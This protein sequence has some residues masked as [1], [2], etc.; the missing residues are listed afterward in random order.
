MSKTMLALLIGG[1]VFL[2]ILAA[3]CGLV[4]FLLFG[5]SSNLGF[6]GGSGASTKEILA[7]V[8]NPENFELKIPKN[9]D[10]AISYLEIDS[11]TN[12]FRDQRQKWLAAEWLIEQPVEP[13]L[14]TRASLAL[15]QSFHQAKIPNSGYSKALIRAFELWGTTEN[16][17]LFIATR[18]GNED[19]TPVLLKMFEKYPNVS[20]AGFVGDQ[21][22]TKHITQAE[23][24]LRL[25][26]P[27]AAQAIAQHYDSKSAVVAESVKKMYADWGTD[28]TEVRLKYYIAHTNET[29]HSDSAWAIIAG[30]PFVERHQP[31]VV[32]ALRSFDRSRKLGVE[33]WL[34]ACLV[35]GDRSMLEMVQQ[36]FISDWSYDRAKALQ[37]MLKFPDKSSVKIIVDM[38]VDG[39]SFTDRQMLANALQQIYEMQIEGVD[40]EE[41]VHKR[42]VV[43]YND[44][45]TS[46][47][48][49]LKELLQ[50]T[51]F[52]TN[53]LVDQSLKELQSRTSSH[54]AVETLS[55]MVVI[56]ARRDEV[57][58]AIAEIIKGDQFSDSSMKACFL[59][60]ATPKSQYLYSM[61]GDD[62]FGGDDWNNALRIALTGEG[63]EAKLIVPVAQAMTDFHKKEAVFNILTESGENS[64]SLML[65]LLTSDNAAEL[66][67]ACRVLS[68]VGTEKSMGPLKKAFDDAKKKQ[69][70]AVQSAA[71]LAGRAVMSRTGAEL[72]TDADE[73]K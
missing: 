64:E 4:G 71:A 26:G 9:V 11:N 18:F 70:N 27:E 21:L 49:G 59:K 57:A 16:V 52:D 47:R 10:E 28:V 3:S 48:S 22:P 54:H 68:V 1:I 13:E 7:R 14:R 50:A 62:K 25:I 65:L 8:E 73:K 63:N 45:F 67:G 30:I 61:L 31:L 34:N 69:M 40:Y 43:K 53:L 44:F 20:L 17:H 46:T 56:D 58:D 41:M 60:W 29:F 36:V 15:G 6:A 55:K 24:V 39:F 38:Y 32:E 5:S 35:W 2:V 37:F 33:D 12:L 66:E 72:P 19:V 23:S 42:L 51:D